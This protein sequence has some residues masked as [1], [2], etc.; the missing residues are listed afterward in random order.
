MIHK[1]CIANFSIDTYRSAVYN[2]LLIYE[3]AKLLVLQ[4]PNDIALI[5][6]N[7]VLLTLTCVTCKWSM[8]TLLV[9]VQEQP[10]NITQLL[11]DRASWH[12]LLHV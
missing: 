4:M 10:H 3:S 7:T 11:L 8:H 6:Y 12:S 1:Q 5:P 9:V 2:R